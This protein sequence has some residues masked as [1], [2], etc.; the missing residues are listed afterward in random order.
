LKCLKDYNQ[1]IKLDVINL[2]DTNDDADTTP[3]GA[4]KD[5]A[6][7]TLFFGE[8]REPLR[9]KKLLRKMEVAQRN[10]LLKRTHPVRPILQTR[11][12]I[13]VAIKKSSSQQ[14]QRKRSGAVLRKKVQ[15]RKKAAEVA[16]V[17]DIYFRT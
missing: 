4:K 7:V 16:Q 5:L 14:M 1:S 11:K 6:V 12:V 17:N 8:R 3:V 10:H 9:R 15:L 2:T 13:M